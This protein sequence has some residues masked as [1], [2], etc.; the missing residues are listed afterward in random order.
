[1]TSVNSPRWS[2]DELLEELRG[3]LQEVPVEDS[4]IRAAQAAFA[5]RTVDADLEFLS[6]AVDTGLTSGA[7]VRGSRPGGPGGPGG[8][9][10][11]VFHGERL[12]VEIEID[13]TGIVGQLVPPQPGQVTLVTADGPQASTQADEVGCFALPAPGPG[14]LRLECQLETGRFVSEWAT[15]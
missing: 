15:A 11:L 6:L 3:A 2:D 12:S 13:E 14:P 8:P 7:Q 4:V 5:W 9:Q 10:T 1:V